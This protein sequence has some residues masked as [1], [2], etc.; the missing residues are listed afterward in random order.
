MVGRR[1]F[2]TKVVMVAGASTTL[3]HQS[4]LVSNGVKGTL[5]GAVE[6]W[7]SSG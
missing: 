2:Q 1:H 5:L 4:V 3:L 6:L 7:Y